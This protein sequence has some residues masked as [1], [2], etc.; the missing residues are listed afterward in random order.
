[1]NG[2]QQDQRGNPVT[3]VASHL[4]RFTAAPAV[5]GP[6][7]SSQRRARMR[8]VRLQP[9]A[10]RWRSR[11]VGSDHATVRKLTRPQI[12]VPE[13][14]ATRVSSTPSASVA[15]KHRPFVALAAAI[16]RS[17]LKEGGM[18]LQATVPRPRLLHLRQVP[19]MG[20]VEGHLP[21]RRSKPMRASSA[22]TRRTVA[23]GH[24]VGRRPGSSR[25][26]STQHPVRL[27]WLEGLLLWLLPPGATPGR[28]P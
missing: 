8:A 1:M 11:V 5:H 14:C 28:A 10:Q 3:I 13:S 6:A 23:I 21:R 4:L 27:E 22:C 19:P 15:M 16:L 20:S 17:P 24:A 2:D 12:Q 7:C 26:S 25:G 18:R 9:A